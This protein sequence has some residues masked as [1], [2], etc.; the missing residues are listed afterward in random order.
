MRWTRKRRDDSGTALILALMFVT[1][2]GLVVGSLLTY[3]AA[4]IHAATVLAERAQTDYDVDG[5]LQAA[6][7]NV[8]QSSYNN[9]SGQTCLSSGS[10]DVP[11]ASGG[12]VRVV[13]SAGAGT[14]AAAGLVPITSAN[15]PGSAIL[16]LGTNG[17]EPG[18]GLQSN[19]TL[20]VKGRVVSNSSITGGGASSVLSSP[21]AQVKAKG[22]CS[23][24][25][26]SSNPAAV[27]NYTPTSDADQFADPHDSSVF[28][29]TYTKYDPPPTAVSDLT[30]RSVP[31]CG[32]SPITFQ[33]GYY[34]DA[35]ALS[36]LTNTA[37]AN[38]TLWFRPGQYYFDFHNLEGG[39]GLS[40]NGGKGDVWTINDSSIRIVA[41]TPQGWTTSPFTAP[42]IPG[43]CVSPLTTTSN[44][45][46]QFA[47]G[48][49]SR[50]VLTSGQMEVC[51]QYYSDKPSLAVYGM[52][53]GSDPTNT[54]VLKTNGSGS[55]P[56]GNIAFSPWSAL[57]DQ[58][59][60][61]ASATLDSTGATTDTTAGVTVSGFSTASIPAG[62]ILKSAQI[63]VRHR[64][65]VTSG[66]LKSI[67]ASG[68][69]DTT[70]IASTNLTSSSSWHTD[71]ITVPISSIETKLHAG[72]TVTSNVTVKAVVAR[73]TGSNPQNIV[74]VDLDSIQLRLTYK[75]PAV[76]GETTNINGA[77]NCIGTAPFTSTQNCALV[78]TSGAQSRLY[79]QGTTYTP[80]AALDIS[81]TN[82]SS[83]VFRAGLITRSLRITVTASS[84]YTGPVIEVPDDSQGF[85]S[86]PLDM[87]F[88][89]YVCPDGSTCTGVSPPS[90]PWVAMGQ[91]RASFT[92]TSITPTPGSRQVTVQSWHVPR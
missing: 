73:K 86:A 46:V 65:T 69:V 11:D 14:G 53:S 81:L 90:S 74:T 39:G 16:T 9:A 52:P 77:A 64:E 15:K 4:N 18:L 75:P 32:S 36:A 91:A 38:H 41:G 5:A 40:S 20:L 2:I 92:D 13:C 50:L 59:N 10:L 12:T 27:C 89:A 48:G 66:S 37:C 22:S 76:R 82:V 42:T 29:T 68:T 21:Y 23:T 79:F 26:I 55:T 8:R 60:T 19:G 61:A 71:T 62:S 87:Y 67:S 34:D 30:Y 84:S 45:G 17:S 88:T 70:A 43:S 83:Q 85:A 80:K 56:T 72:T 28:P 51:G 58:D 49:D 31:S 7:N 1:G 78:T 24:A 54:A 47:F 33:P 25:T 6:I 35:A 44:N 3:S 63:E 57:Q